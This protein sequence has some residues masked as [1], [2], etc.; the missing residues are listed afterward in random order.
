M[1]T[2][3]VSGRV[4]EA[5]RQRADI[6]MRKAGVTP[7]DVIQN[8]WQAMART[9]EVPDIARANTAPRNAAPSLD[10]LEHFLNSLPPVNQAYAAMT[11]EEILRLRVHDHE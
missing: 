2:A 3:V 6:A 5:V 8:V 10:R 4:D 11:D 9:G 7:T 1:A